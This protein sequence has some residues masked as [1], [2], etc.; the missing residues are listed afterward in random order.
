MATL[1]ASIH[2]LCLFPAFLSGNTTYELSSDWSEF[3]FVVQSKLILVEANVNDLTGYFLFDTGASEL[4]LNDYYFPPQHGIKSEDPYFDT[5]GLGWNY[6]FSFVKQ[7]CWNNI[8]REKY[9]TPCVPMESIEAALDVTLLGIIGQ[10]VFKNATLWMDYEHRKMIIGKN[11]E[12]FQSFFEKPPHLQHQFEMEGHLP[13]LSVDIAPLEDLRL[14]LDSG[15]MMDLLSDRLERKLRHDAVA[16]RHFSLLGGSD[17][18]HRSFYFI[19]RELETQEMFTLRFGKVGFC[20]L[21]GMR[22]YDIQID[23]F[24]GVNFFRLGQVLIDYQTQQI[25]IWA[26]MNDY[27]IRLKDRIEEK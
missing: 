16:K 19:M 26:T 5:N 11:Y 25:A 23:G 10:E 6:G 22:S 21:D 27:T 15:A 7:F 14:G 24:L 3:E 9:H 17:Q 18:Y 20:N 2:W 13:V 8:K 1:R 4:I 12:S